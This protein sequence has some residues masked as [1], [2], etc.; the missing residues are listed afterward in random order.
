MIDS[1]A[2]HFLTAKDELGCE[3][4]Q[5]ITPLTGY[6]DMGL[7]YGIDNGAF[8]GFEEKR[9]L[10]ILHRQ[11]SSRERCR[12]V[13]SPDVVGS[14][15][16]TAEVF[17]LWSDRLRG[18]PVALVAQDGIEDVAIPWDSISAV[19]IGG[20]TAFK[21]SSVARAVVSAA[22]ILGKWTHMGRV[23]TPMRF[24]LAEEWGIDSIDGTGISRY[25]HMR[26]A[27]NAPNLFST[28]PSRTKKGALS[29]PSTE[30]SDCDG[31]PTNDAILALL[32]GTP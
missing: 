25:S 16:R 22:K 19:F 2:A 20:S 29:V 1:S 8:S 9:F 5:L 10:A 26:M 32:K 13:C 27:I 12:F 4:G 28:P 31:G 6:S 24:E 23:N 21:T 7:V 18:W 14:A 30:G 3:V 17:D 15:R 11:R